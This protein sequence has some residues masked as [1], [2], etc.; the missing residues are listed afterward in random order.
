MVMT[1]AKFSNCE[2][3][4]LY[5]RTSWLLLERHDHAAAARFWPASTACVDALDLCTQNTAAENFP[6]E[7]YFYPARYAD[8]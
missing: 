3:L 7:L 4:S 1:E 5:I 2:E 6:L 8:E